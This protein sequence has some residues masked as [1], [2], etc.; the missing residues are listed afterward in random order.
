VHS[1]AGSKEW[2]VQTAKIENIK[3]GYRPKVASSILDYF[4]PAA[5][6]VK[7][8]PYIASGNVANRQA[9]LALLYD[10]L[11]LSVKEDCE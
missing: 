2:V 6:R 11:C 4:S 10:S 3:Y 9:Y 1:P 7:E 8:T 5:N